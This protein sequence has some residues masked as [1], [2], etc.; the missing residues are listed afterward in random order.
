MTSWLILFS[1][2]LDILF[3]SMIGGMIILSYGNYFVGETVGSPFVIG[4]F[5]LGSLLYYLAG[6]FLSLLLNSSMTA[7][8]ILLLFPLLVMPFL[9]RVSPEISPYVPYIL[10]AQSLQGSLGV[11]QLCALVVWCV[12]LFLF[13]NLQIRKEFRK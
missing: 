1:E 2:S 4:Y 8:S 13:S 6:Y 12:I 10:I 11:T 3:H 9:N 5:L 7:L